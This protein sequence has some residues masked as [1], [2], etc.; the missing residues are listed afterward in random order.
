MRNI[1][2]SLSLLTTSLGFSQLQD[3]VQMKSPQSYSFEKYGNVPVNLYM[4][5]IDMKLPLASIGSDGN[6]S[7][8]LI[9]DSSGFIP[10]K[11]S[12]A[13]GTN[14]SLFAGG[15]ISRTLN[16]IADEYIDDGMHNSM[17][18]NGF[19]AGVRNYPSIN[20]QAYNLYGGTGNTD[21]NFYWWMGPSNNAYEGTPDIFNFNAP[22]IS[23][24]FMIGNDG[25]ALVESTD[26]NIKVDISQ[27]AVYG[28]KRFCTPPS[29]Q[30]IITD[31]QGNKYFFGGDLTKYEIS[32]SYSYMNNPDVYY[33]GYP[34]INSFS[35]S[36]I[37]FANG[38]EANF[39]Y[40]QGTV[41]SQ[42]FCNLSTWQN[43]HANSNLFSYESYTQDGATADD[44]K[45]CPGGLF[46]CAHESSNNQSNFTTFVMLKKSVLKSIKFGDD[47]IKI[48]YADLG[49]PI[50][51]WPWINR[52]LNE[53]VVN[54]VETYHK[55]ILVKK[56]ELSYDHLGG[57]SKRPFLKSL[58]FNNNG[59]TYLFDYYKTSSLP[60]YY[61]KGIDHWGYWNGKDSNEGLAP[62]DTYNAATGDYTLNNTFRDADPQKYDVA[63]LSKVTYPTKGYSIFEY[64]PQYYG[65]RVERIS[66]SLFLPTLTNNTGLAGGSRIRSI[67]NYAE[68]GVLSTKK[69]YK[70][71]KTIDGTVSSGILMNWPRYYY[72]VEAYSNSAVQKNM[73]KTSSNVQK[74]SLD[75]YNI[76][77]SR[78]F[79]IDQNG[80]YIEH[81]FTSYETHPD[82]LNPDTNNLRRYM[83]PGYTTIIP[84][85][86]SKNFANLFGIDKS[87]LRGRPLSQKFY[88]QSD[89]VN[90]IKTLEYEYYDNMDYNP[91]NLRDNNNYVSIN[92]LSGYWVQ[93]YRRFMNSAP[94]KRI[95]TSN[96][97]N[98]LNV[99][100]K[101][102]FLYNSSNHLNLSEQTIAYP[103]GNIAKE[104]LSYVYDSHIPDIFKTVMINKNMTSIPMG[105]KSYKNNSKVY[106]EEK[107]YAP[108]DPMPE[109]LSTRYLPKIFYSNIGPNN[110][111]TT[112][113]SPDKKYTI[114]KYDSF[115]NIVQYTSENSIPITLIWGYNNTQLIAKVE[116]A[117]YVAISQSLIDNIVN[118]SN[119]DNQQ[120]TVA[121]EQS[122]IDALDNFRK[123]ISLGQYQITTYTYDPLIGIRS[124]TP[125]SGIKEIY[126][127]D[128]ENRLKEIREN[129][130]TGRVLK[131]YTY[132]FKN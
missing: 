52:Y 85:N 77:Y 44:W 107:I 103:D 35:L 62:F 24:K 128:T 73:L 21:G 101:K 68:N 124:I 108:A 125:P 34:M 54:N 49:Y 87:I 75:A 48:K 33:E 19:L 83:L 60:A 123:D 98:G 43:I 30:I 66:A 11:K 61:T 1:Y 112:S 130:Q 47:E 18:R 97:F 31:G 91:N 58:K 111:N 10:H 59:E 41:N 72:Y 36:K 76:G 69:Q 86:L 127:Y 64:E 38:Q 17:K 71:T 110:L 5:S 89:W 116:G 119:N 63:L 4:G 132:N 118:A 106:E 93:G 51:Q 14:W 40:E 90:P 96:Y 16:G 104:N 27:M 84:E 92:H 120:G 15:R 131:G 79:E 88:S 56:V 46:G 74:N 100:T 25:K 115:S 13:A 3:P 28:G 32:Y 26:P 55:N 6:I 9:Y 99:T 39:D 65:N 94:L 12:D 20:T 82:L 42:L 80:G 95:S 45:N 57:S 7:A 105:K 8:T 53:W 126:L 67:S 2:I 70:Y 37:I 113:T 102:E 114:D 78:V 122:L 22:G 117:S 50:E 129:N 29:S 121:S 81:N 23:G 109:E